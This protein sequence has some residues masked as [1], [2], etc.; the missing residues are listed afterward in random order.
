[1]AAPPQSDAVKVQ[2]S[3]D[4]LISSKLQTHVLEEDQMSAFLIA[5]DIHSDAEGTVVLSGNAE[6]RRI[7]S[8]V[9]GDRIDYHRSTGQLRVRGN[10]LIMRDA[11]IVK[12]PAFDYNVDAETGEISEPNFWLGATGGAGE[13]ESANIF[14]SDHMR[15]NQVTYSGCPCP[16]PAWYIKSRPVDQQF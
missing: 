7:D 2:A 3:N 13:A 12:A 11:N 1:M 8:V 6:V 16:D 5:D 14:S 10:G 4:L 15:L 9:K